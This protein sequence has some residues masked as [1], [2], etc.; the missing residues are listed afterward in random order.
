[1]METAFA[2]GFTQ[3][4]CAGYFVLVAWLNCIM[5][6]IASFYRKK[7]NQPAPRYGFIVAIGFAVLYIASMF[8][9]VSSSASQWNPFAI[10]RTSCLIGSAFASGWSSV[11]LLVVM[12]KARK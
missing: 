12:K 7:F 6:L 10:V 8:F 9:P 1:M 4:L 2:L 5:Y 3:V 11:N